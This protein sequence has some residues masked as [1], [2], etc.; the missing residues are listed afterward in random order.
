MDPTFKDKEYILT[1]L[2]SMRFSDPQ[3]GD[4]IVFQAP[5]DENK[6]FIKRVMA[7]PGDTISIQNGD[8]YVNGVMVDE[9]EYLDST[10]ETGAGAF[11]SEGEEIVVPEG[12]YV[13]M[14]DNRNASSDSREWGFLDREE[15][16][17]KSF[18]VYWPVQDFRIITNPF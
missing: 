12:E 17:G 1:N 6:D 16:I 15:I 7:V 11:M 5:T 13:V 14:G 3:K 10:V 9:S 8:V 18:F 2:I 4:V